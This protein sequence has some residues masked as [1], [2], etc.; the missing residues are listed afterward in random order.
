MKSTILLV[1]DDPAV[2]RMLLRILEDEDYS[3]VPAADG[4]EAVE[5]ASSS[6]PDL[7]LLDLNLPNQSGWD[8]FRQ[9]TAD[10]PQLPVIIITA[11]S[12]QIFPALA[13][14]VGALMEKPLDLPKLLRM[15]RHLLEEPAEARLARTA[16]Q[17][18][19]FHYLP[20]RR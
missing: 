17:P 16:G 14:G 10:Q 2:R 20:P 19:E 15:I 5:I 4:A 6:P 18:A 11:R 8:T 3:V 7:L 12:N 1:D 13:S 9:L